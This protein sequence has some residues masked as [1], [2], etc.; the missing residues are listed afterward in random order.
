ME[1]KMKEKVKKWVI[2]GWMVWVMAGGGVT[3]GN[4]EP[5]VIVEPLLQTRWSQGAPY[6]SMLRELA[7]AGVGDINDVT[8]NICGIVAWAQLMRYHKY[9]ARGVG[10]SEPWTHSNGVNFPSVNFETD[11]DWDNMLY[12]YTGS[13]TDHQRNVVAELY[14]II[15][16]GRVNRLLETVS[17][18]GYDKSI[19]R[20]ER[21]YY[22]DTAWEAMIKEQLNLG[23]PVYYWGTGNGSHAFI[24]DGYDDAGRFHVNWGWGGTHNGYYSLNA[25]NPGNSD[26]SNN[27]HMIINFKPDQGGVSAGY[28]LA[29]RNFSV[30]KTNVSQNELFTVSTQVRNGSNF[31]SFQ[32]GRWGVA[33]VDGNDDII[34]IMGDAAIQALTPGLSTFV[35]SLNCFV[36]ETIRPGEYRLKVAISPEGED[37]RIITK[38]AIGSNI[39]S[40]INIIVT[41]ERGA[42]GGG[43]GLELTVF[44]VDKTTVSQ[45]ESFTVTTRTRNIGVQRW[46]GGQTGAAL[47]DNNGNI[48]VI[49]GTRNTGALSIG[50]SNTNPFEMNSTIPNTVSPGQYRL[51]IVIKPKDSGDWKIAT[52]SSPD[53]PNSIDFTVADPNS[54]T[55]SAS[56]GNFT[57]MPN[58]VVM[59]SSSGTAA[60][61]WQGARL[62]SGTV[63]P[64]YNASGDII[65]GIEIKDPASA[66][67]SKRRIASWNL[68][69]LDGR[70]APKGRY[71]VRGVLTT[72]DGGKE[73]VELSFDIR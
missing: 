49:V 36:P 57:V 35:I 47:V 28:D 29:L 52:L 68:R 19:R 34:S 17:N 5:V 7:N 51:R 6:N 23:L 22:D 56:S 12:T 70:P 11:F 62:A 42:T 65:N 30:N 48:V 16:I 1:R 64:V 2:A 25:L 24:L 53:I 39:P 50:F 40:T 14:Y 73:R 41:A 33:L 37:W 59:T 66:S 71:T 38:S 54:P 9:P 31:D 46:D 18:F 20:L 44:T 32:G 8:V 58:P 27:Q 67:P 61:F 45:N 43:H 4:A 21:L 3:V 60:F 69:D 15:S 63:L 13:A 10:Q 55:P 72:S 26:F